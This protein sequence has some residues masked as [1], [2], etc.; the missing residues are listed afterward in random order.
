MILKLF[1][2]IIGLF[3]E[4][5]RHQ[6]Y[7]QCVVVPEFALDNELS[8]E[9][10]RTKDD[11]ESAYRLLHDCYVGTKLMLPNDS[12]LRCNLYT[13]FP[14]ST[15]IIAK[16]KG[17]I[18]GTVS[19]IRDSGWGLPSDKDYQFENSQL[20]KRGLKLVEVSALAVSRK[21][22]KR[23]NS[24][25][26]LLMKYL[27]NYTSGY[28]NS[29]CLVCTVHPRAEDFYK[30]LWHFDR[31][32]Q[33]VEYNFVQGAL[34][35]HLSMEISLEKQNK[36]VASYGT[37]DPLR[38]LA[39]FVL[40]KD[41]RFKYPKR[42]AG[43]QIDPVLTPDLFEY[44]CIRKTDVWET[45]SVTEK[46][47]LRSIYYSL[48]GFNNPVLNSI[49]DAGNSGL[50]EYRVPIEVG[51]IVELGGQRRSVKVTDVSPGGAYLAWP[52]E[53]GIPQSKMT[54]SLK[55]KNSIVHLQAEVAWINQ[56]KS[57]LHPYGFGVKFLNTHKNQS[58]NFTNWLYTE[59]A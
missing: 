45:L 40:K 49:S 35:V 57:H 24:V 53:I 42:Q 28:F 29:D 17:E 33:V 25:S 9:I 39:L 46:N 2:S 59:A 1:L 52:K 11:L 54:L 16:Y 30:S 12:G 27:Y 47:C 23:G 3:P 8:I 19:L 32:G 21:F 51:A 34:A 6:F 37:D 14:H 56:G 18:V 4:K 7:R 31:N 26:L 44:F 15:V 50:R 5:W 41:L 55:I 10:A 20:R 22:R 43:S 48:F 38:N 13:F 58:F 36:I